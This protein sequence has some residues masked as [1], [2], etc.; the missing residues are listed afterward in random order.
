MAARVQRKEGERPEGREETCAEDRGP[1][2][3]IAP[4]D[5][6][7]TGGQ[8]PIRP[9]GTT[10]EGISARKKGPARLHLVIN[11]QLGKGR[12]EAPRRLRR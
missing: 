4:G 7:E 5:S 11:E 9:G 6:E 1:S 2:W 3:K 8:K 10:P 12:T